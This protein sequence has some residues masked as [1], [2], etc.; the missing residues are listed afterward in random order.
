MKTKKK[1]RKKKREKLYYRLCVA[2]NGFIAFTD[3]AKAKV[4]RGEQRERA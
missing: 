4:T 2:V 1:E 3:T